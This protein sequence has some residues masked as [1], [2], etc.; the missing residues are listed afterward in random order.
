MDMTQSIE[1]RSDQWNADDL[2]AGPV[3][4]TISEVIEGKAEH[5]FDFKLVE[6]PGRAYRPSKTCRRIIVAAWGSDTKAY[7]GRRLTLYREASI[8]FGG[9]RVGGIR[10]SAMSDIDGPVTVQAQTTRG[11]RETFIV[12][13]LATAGAGSGGP[14]PAARST[15][16][17]TDS[18]RGGEHVSAGESPASGTG[19]QHVEGAAS[20]DAPGA[21]L[22]A[23]VNRQV[24]NMQASGQSAHLTTWAQYHGVNPPTSKAL[25]ERFGEEARDLSALMASMPTDVPA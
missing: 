9:Q 7:A 16:D 25:A 21:S 4:V 1:P 23:A 24:K 13:P 3:T 18:E 15:G 20:P 2:I 17:T 10:V 6:T 5:P 14:A 22:L 11:K 8:M 12:K 19:A